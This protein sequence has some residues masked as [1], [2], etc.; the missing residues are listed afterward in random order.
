MFCAT[1]DDLDVGRE[2]VVFEDKVVG[3]DVE[4]V[5]LEVVNV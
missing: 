1:V 3:L 5:V 2:G 4:D